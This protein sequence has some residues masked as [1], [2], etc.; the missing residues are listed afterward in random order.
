MRNKIQ[1][2]LAGSM[3]C[4]ADR[5]Y[6]ALLA[7][8]I[9]ER[10]GNYIDLYVPQENLSINDKT[11]CANSH[12]IFWGD[13]NRLQRCDIFIAR[14]DGDIPPSGT[15][16][17]IGI[18]SQRRQDWER[19]LNKFKANYYLECGRHATDEQIIEYKQVEGFEP[20]ILGLCTDSRNPKRTYLDAKNELMKNEDYESQ[21]C[22]FNLFTLGCIKVNGELATSIDELVDKLETAVRVRI[23]ESNVTTEEL[24]LRSLRYKKRHKVYSNG[25]DEYFEEVVK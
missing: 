6:N 22:Y 19:G 14:I 12:D 25:I 15:S 24:D 9:R 18:M 10:V 21:Y 4:E 16:A 3:F 13:Y 7:Q 17:E 23:V 8:K 20:M 2:Y 1:V 5:M 11:K